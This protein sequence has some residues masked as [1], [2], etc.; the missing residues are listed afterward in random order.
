MNHLRQLVLG[1]ALWATASCWAGVPA[2]YAPMVLQPGGVPQR[3]EFDLTAAM[4]RAQAER[5]RLYVYLGADD[6]PFCRVYEAFLG[7]NSGEL[8]SHFANQ[9]LV[10]DL[11]SSLKAQADKLYFRVGDKVLNYTEFQRE[12]GDE[13]LRQLVYPNVWLLDGRGKMLIQMP[14]G[15]GTFQTV[16]EQLEILRLEQ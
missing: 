16:P 3:W 7:K 10:V 14:A 2:A 11:R 6:C 5:K 15:A 4:K 1:L 12:L 13:R 8:A 9:Y